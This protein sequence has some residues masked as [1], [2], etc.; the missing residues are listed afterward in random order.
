MLLLTLS[1]F[2]FGFEFGFE[3]A[4]EITV[5]DEKGLAKRK[6][7][8][9]L[10]NL[11]NAILSTW[12]L[13]KKKRKMANR[14]FLIVEE[15]ITKNNFNNLKTSEFTFFIIGFSFKK[16]HIPIKYLTPDI[17]LGIKDN[18]AFNFWWIGFLSFHFIFLKK[19]STL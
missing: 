8:W 13:R 7:R 15:G 10:N 1:C 5:E 12:C 19:E 16:L 2:S 3:I 9:E 6:P 4:W 17:L 11:K 18:S 14:T